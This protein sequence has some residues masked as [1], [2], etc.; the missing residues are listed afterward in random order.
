MSMPDL[1]RVTPRTKIGVQSPIRI[2]PRNLHPF[3]EAPSAQGGPAGVPAGASSSAD[4]E[5]VRRND[6]RRD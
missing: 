1:A 6:T 4:S 3:D 2:I 5:Y